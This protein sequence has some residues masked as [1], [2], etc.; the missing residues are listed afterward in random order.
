MQFSLKL[1]VHIKVVACPG[2][3]RLSEARFLVLVYIL[4]ELLGAYV[5][6]YVSEREARAVA[7]QA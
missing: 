2:V 3:A 4:K 7:S 6:N 5:I 1:L